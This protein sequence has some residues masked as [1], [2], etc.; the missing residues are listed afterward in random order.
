MGQGGDRKREEGN[1][2]GGGIGEGGSALFAVLS[3]LFLELEILY[4]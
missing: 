2:S 1:G 3:L 4:K